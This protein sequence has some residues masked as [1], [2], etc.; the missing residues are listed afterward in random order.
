MTFDAPIAPGGLIAD[1][2]VEGF[3]RI[4]RLAG[5]TI[6]ADVALVSFI[7]GVADRQVFLGQSGLPEPWATARCTPLTHSF[8]QHVVARDAVLDVEDARTHPLVRDNLAV[9][10]LGV[11]AYLGHPVYT[12]E[13]TPVAALCVIATQPRR[14]T[15]RDHE[16]VRDFAAL[17]DDQLALILA[18][19]AEK[20]ALALQRD[21]AASKERFLAMMSHE[22]RTPLTGVLGMAD[23]M[24]ESA[25]SPEQQTIAQAIRSSGA[26]LLGILN[27]IL[28]MARLG[29]GKLSVCREP[30]SLPD[31]IE[32]VARPARLLAADKGIGFEVITSGITDSGL[33]GMFIGDRLCLQ[34][35][36]SNLLS[37]ALKFTSQGQVVLHV[38]A[39]APAAESADPD[40]VLQGPDVVFR[41]VDTGIGMDPAQIER[42]FQPF[43]QADATT[44]RR[45]GGSGLGMRIVR[46]LAE[47][48]G[49]SIEVQSALGVGTGITVRMPLPRAKS[50][51]GR[52]DSAAEIGVHAAP[53]VPSVPEAL[54]D[55]A[56]VTASRVPHRQGGNGLL[57]GKVVLVADDNATNRRLLA[58]HKTGN[59]SF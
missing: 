19:R 36:L 47:L 11:I 56:L 22:I 2:D 14:W 43:E 27:N 53:P 46:S 8:C 21:L 42:L 35:I 7:E 44:A 26:D 37:N 51:E 6:G 3:D 33:G 40:K 45:Y 39:H 58:V 13:G 5:R 9:P 52:E 18:L 15:S 31:L 28:D 54:N 32:A 59:G 10:D 29:E 16:M 50:P 38:E 30:F 41:V 25:L 48:L 1:G 24:V 4:A 57:A 20:S 55:T 23:L 12:P 49:G 17:A 34:Q